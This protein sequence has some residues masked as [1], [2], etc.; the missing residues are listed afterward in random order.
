MENMG[1]DLKPIVQKN[2]VW[3]QKGT[4]MNDQI[5]INSY[6]N[7]IFIH[8]IPSGSP[9]PSSISRVDPTPSI[10]LPRADLHYEDVP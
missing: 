10:N 1:T 4:E 9:T 3:F 7:I 6:I 8:Q 2:V 5:Q